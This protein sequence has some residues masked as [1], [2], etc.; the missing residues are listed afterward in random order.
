MPHSSL[1]KERVVFSC[2]IYSMLSV[3]EDNLNWNLDLK[4]LE[5]SNKTILGG[6][7]ANIIGRQNK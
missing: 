7:D 3:I 2:R 4:L 6:Q 5:S 1:S